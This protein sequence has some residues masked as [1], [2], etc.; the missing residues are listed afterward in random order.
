M[1]L[2]VKGSLLKRRKKDWRREL[3]GRAAKQV[4]A[5]Y[6]GGCRDRLEAGGDSAVGP[7]CGRV[8]CP[9]DTA[10]GWQWKARGACHIGVSWPW[11]SSL[12]SLHPQAGSCLLL[13]SEQSSVF[14]RG[15]WLL[16]V[17]LE[18]NL[19]STPGKTGEPKAYLG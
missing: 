2:R 17:L 18:G 9:Q 11:A 10:W 3:L 6:S 15:L 4:A 1:G 7:G 5:A 8:R 19:P 13:G 12:S 14:P 16:R